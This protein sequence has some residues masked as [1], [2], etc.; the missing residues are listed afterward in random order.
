MQKYAPIGNIVLL[1]NPHNSFSKNNMIF[2]DKKSIKKIRRFMPRH[3][4]CSYCSCSFWASKASFSI[5]WERLHSSIGLEKFRSGFPLL[6]SIWR[7]CA[8]MRN[9]HWPQSG[10]WRP[11]L[12]SDFAGLS[13]SRQMQRWFLF[14]ALIDENSARIQAHQDLAMY[15]TNLTKI[16]S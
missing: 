16:N 1:N 5:C 11:M 13:A 10:R 9:V 4:I 12:L 8:C 7:S 6:S 2:T 3:S 14:K 15:V